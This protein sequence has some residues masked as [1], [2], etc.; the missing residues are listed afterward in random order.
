MSGDE[1]EAAAGPIPRKDRQGFGMLHNKAFQAPFQAA[2]ASVSHT[3]PEE[4]FI[5]TYTRSQV[6]V[7]VE[8]LGRQFQI[9]AKE[10]FSEVSEKVELDMSPR[11]LKK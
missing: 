5:G 3:Y 2:I 10:I 1:G 7:I 9:A 6:N 4:D 11:F 8:C